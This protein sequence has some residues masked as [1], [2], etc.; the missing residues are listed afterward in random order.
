VAGCEHL[1]QAHKSVLRN[2][3][4]RGTAWILAGVAF[5]QAMGFVNAAVSLRFVDVTAF[6]SFV[7]LLSWVT[8]FVAVVTQGLHHA[9]TRFLA[10]HLARNQDRAARNV[11]V[12]IRW[13]IVVAAAAIAFIS[14]WLAKSVPDSIAEFFP[15]QTAVA[16]FIGYVLLQS[17][18]NVDQY[19]ALGLKNPRLSSV[20]GFFL[21]PAIRLVLLFSI[22]PLLP[23]TA[24]LAVAFGGSLLL[25]LVVAEMLL[26]SAGFMLGR[27]SLLGAGAL[28]KY[29][30]PLMISDVFTLLLFQAD[31]LLLGYLWNLEAVGVY[32]IA[33]RLAFLTVAPH[34]AAA[35]VYSPLM[36][37]AWTVGQL[38]ELRRVFQ[39]N[40]ERFLF[41]TGAVGSI[42]VINAPSILGLF[43][44]EFRDPRLADVVQILIVGLW[45]S[46]A[47]G[48]QGQFYRMT[49]RSWITTV[50]SA[51]AALLAVGLGFLWIPNHDIIGAALATA[52]AVVT[53]NVCGLLWML[54]LFGSRLH[55]F[56]S[57]YARA[58]IAGAALLVLG[59]AGA[60]NPVAGTVASLVALGILGW[61]VLRDEARVLLDRLSRQE[62]HVDRE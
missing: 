11:L 37:E 2:Y 57:R 9:A 52:I 46:V 40:T 1:L 50:N 34:W 54:G 13:L 41:V 55:P 16:F 33:S 19:A 22:L 43:G 23:S 49:G 45:L 60:D 39:R 42:L 3:V 25:T 32:M 20:I 59:F 38:D 47:T 21:P 6:G 31:K 26:A 15:I 4:A 18:L 56:G 61:F 53:L 35:N 30:A 5:Q 24:G 10:S 17:L 29:A 8:I 27:P 7:F 28:Y 14:P 58:A 51:L 36:A 62:H 48:H 44:E 12:E